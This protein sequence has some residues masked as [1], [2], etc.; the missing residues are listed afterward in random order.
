MSRGA[1]GTG[2]GEENSLSTEYQLDEKLARSL[3]GL[4]RRERSPE[5]DLWPG[6]RERIES[7]ERSGPKRYWQAWAAVLVLSLGLGAVLW[8]AFG[9]QSSSAPV[10]FEVGALA[11]LPPE[12]SASLREAFARH[13]SERAPLVQS[14]ARSLDDYPPE[15]RVEIEDNL[16]TI[17]NAM[18]QIEDSLRSAGPEGDEEQRLAAL[19]DFELRLLRSLNDRLRGWPGASSTS[20]EVSR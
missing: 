2:S 19:I 1:G 9:N 7:L 6:I 4:R 12:S 5:S 20:W 11:D 18:E 3:A 13:R 14:L 16:R 10:D 17:A 15:L 8:L